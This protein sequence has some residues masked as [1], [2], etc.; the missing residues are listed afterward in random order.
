MGVDD[1]RLKFLRQAQQTALGRPHERP[2]IEHRQPAGDARW[3]RRTVEMQA[4]RRFFR[5]R[6][7]DLFWTRQVIRLPAQIALLA[8]DVGAAKGVAGVQRQGMVENVQDAHVKLL[9]IKIVIASLQQTFR[10]EKPLREHLR[11][12]LNPPCS[13]QQGEFLRHD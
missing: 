3:L 13:L 6:T 2:L 10:L 12:P 7:V 1:I 8:Q 11:V 9:K 4:I 5:H